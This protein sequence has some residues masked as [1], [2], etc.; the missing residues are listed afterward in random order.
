MA[1]YTRLGRFPFE[2]LK[3]SSKQFLKGK[4]DVHVSARS[5]SSAAHAAALGNCLT[6]K[7]TPKAFPLVQRLVYGRAVVIPVQNAEIKS[8]DNLCPR[9]SE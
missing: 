2:M 6:H 4:P 1:F 7:D 9:L 5:G 8:G 3:L